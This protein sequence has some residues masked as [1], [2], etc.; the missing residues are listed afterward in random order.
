[1]KLEIF[2]IQTLRRVDHFVAPIRSLMMSFPSCPVSARGS[3]GLMSFPS[4]GALSGCWLGLAY[5]DSDVSGIRLL[6]FFG[7]GVG[8][9][10]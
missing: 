7:G 9:M 8:A 4:F 2:P 10:S 6:L 3:A 1:M 5:W